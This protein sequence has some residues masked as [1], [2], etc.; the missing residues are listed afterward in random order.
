MKKLFASLL[1]L[2][3]LLT[4]IP[5]GAVSVSAATSGDYTYTVT[6]GKAT[7]TGYT[8]YASA[9]TIP[10]KLNG[11]PVTAIGGWAFYYRDNLTSV[12]IPNSVKTIDSGAFCYCSSLISV[13]LPNS[14]TTIG[15]CAFYGCDS[16]TS[17][18]IPN[19]V[20][21]IGDDAFQGCYS[22]TCIT[23][24][25]KN[26]WYASVD[27]VLFNKKKTELI[28]C[29]SSK[30]GTYTIPNSV[31]TIK[32]WAFESCTKLTT[33]IIPK[34]VKTI[35]DSAF[36]A[37][38]NLSVAKD[39]PYFSSENG[40]LFNKKKTKL[41]RCPA[42][43]SGAYTIPNGVTA[44]EDLA[45]RYCGLT[46][47]TIP[48]SVKTIG[49]S[50]FYGCNGLI[51]ATIPNSVTSI[52]SN[53]FYAC[54]SLEK[55]TT[56]FFGAFLFGTYNDIT[57]VPSSL[58]TVVITGGT[59]IPEDTFCKFTGLTSVTL[60]DSITSIGSS[61]FSGCEKLKKITLGKKVKTIGDRA[62]SGCTSLTSITIPDSVTTIG[63]H[64][65]S[66]CEKLAKIT[67]GKKVKT[68]GEYAFYNCSKLTSI[69]L[70]DSVTTIEAYA[71][72]NCSKLA[73]IVLSKNLKSIDYNAFSNCAFTSITIPDSV[74]SISS[75]A[76]FDCEKLK[77][78]TLGKGVKTL[79]N[80][81]DLGTGPIFAG[82]NSLTS[83][84]VSSKNPYFTSVDGVL[85]NKKKTKLILFPTGKSGAY[86]VPKGTTTIASF[87]F[88]DCNKLT[89]LAISDSVKTVEFCAISQCKNLKK[90]TLG[91]GVKTFSAVRSYYAGPFYGCSK[92]TTLTVSKDNPYFSSANNVLFNKKKTTL[93][94]CAPGKTGSYVIPDS[95]TTVQG[96][97]LRDNLSAVVVPTSVKTFESYY[98][99]S[100]TRHI[101][102]TGTRSQAKKINFSGS[103]YGWIVPEE[104]IQ[105]DLAMWHY[106]TCK[107]HK[108]TNSCDK[109]CN[110]CD[111]VRTIKHT[112][113]N[114]CD[115]TCNVCKAKR[116]IQHTYKVVA[117]KKATPTADGKGKQ[118]CS[119]CGYTATKTVTIHKANKISLSTTS[120]TYTGSV[121]KPTV[122][123]KDAKGKTIP[124]KYYTVT[125]AT[126][127][128]N[129]GTY[130]VTVKMKGNYS[131]TKTI[132]FKINPPKTALSSLTA[133]SKKL[134][135]KWA[136]KTTQVTGYQIQYS[137]SK[138]FSSAK[139]KTITKNSTV[140]TSL[141]GLSAKKTYYVRIRTYKTVNGVKIYSAW[142]TVKSLKTK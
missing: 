100:D 134:T 126:G 124:S 37:A 103:T 26:S 5:L 92:L 142:S 87:A 55:L 91:K 23:V 10:S 36:L 84:K 118:V 35:G 107:T 82:C 80:Y 112:Y 105:E 59:T 46:S 21:F 33:V 40:V 78:V 7:I 32:G 4:C 90:L 49:N 123:V 42:S 113:S 127:R 15:E 110:K 99:A 119:V 76:F 88:Y 24:S 17:V 54:E 41:I 51:S 22:L 93:V 94:L 18:T 68:I 74:T 66:R 115:K 121:K 89:S 85:F 73:K 19:N 83:I 47:V 67:L 29:P 6:D 129:V 34:S 52:G 62:F 65:F 2:V 120:Y 25:Q 86:T 109:T 13:T 98:I 48:N 102:Y 50:A 12:T 97:A 71:F 11:Y 64:A 131:G 139:T 137:T 132:T 14:V 16:L 20:A 101:Y 140:S 58:E 72:Y 116:T 95:V 43:K 1:A 70:P 57:A 45:F 108:Y 138:S 60:P 53:V 133:G 27:G 44:I 38:P 30:S 56:P 8:G 31:T 3:L 69:T 39:N 128:K 130:K 125:Y 81:C 114:A 9:I 75:D 77:T 106:N 63:D 122:T 136:K 28:L 79:H 111:W 117:T 141:T 135:V 96:D 61:A 104:A